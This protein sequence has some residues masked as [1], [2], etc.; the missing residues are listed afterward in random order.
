VKLLIDEEFP[1]PN[2][3]DVEHR[4]VTVVVRR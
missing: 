3:L 1:S 4:H 2:K